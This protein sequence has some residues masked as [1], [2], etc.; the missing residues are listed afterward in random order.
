MRAHAREREMKA[1]QRERERERERERDRQTD[2]AQLLYKD[3]QWFRGGLVFEADR[4]LYRSDL[5]LRVMKKNKNKNKKRARCSGL[6]VQGLVRG[7]Q[8]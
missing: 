1:S 6:R 3:V 5:G 2:R 7:V 8:G 4:L